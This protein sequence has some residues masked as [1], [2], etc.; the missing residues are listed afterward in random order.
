[1]EKVGNYFGDSLLKSRWA[2]H[3]DDIST[4]MVYTI[5][6]EEL[7]EPFLCYENEDIKV[8][9]T[10]YRDQFTASNK[11]KEQDNKE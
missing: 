5:L 8:A 7:K 11:Q 10:T 3:R 1:M 2:V 4:A 9:A 6:N